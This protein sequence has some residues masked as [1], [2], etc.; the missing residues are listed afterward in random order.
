[1]ATRD[2][3]IPWVV[4]IRAASTSLATSDPNAGG[5]FTSSGRGES[6]RWQSPGSFLHTIL[7]LFDLRIVAG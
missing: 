5:V 3:G 6:G 7:W 4:Y 2:Q 1:M